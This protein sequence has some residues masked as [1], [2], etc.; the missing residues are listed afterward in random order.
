MIEQAAIVVEA[1][2]DRAHEFAVGPVSKASDHAVGRSHSLDLYHS[3]A[4]AGLI[5]Q[6]NA[7]GDDTVECRTRLAQPPLCNG[8]V[9]RRRREHEMRIA[10]QLSFEELFQ[11]L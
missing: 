10:L 7:L 3:V 1:Q 5:G 9:A 2:K 8:A 6:I 11:S 4:I